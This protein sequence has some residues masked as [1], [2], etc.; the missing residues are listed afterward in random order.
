LT[1]VH[2]VSWNK[3]TGSSFARYFH[4]IHE[5]YGQEVGGRWTGG[6]SEQV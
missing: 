5:N 4:D 6:I 2:A 1:E 3:A